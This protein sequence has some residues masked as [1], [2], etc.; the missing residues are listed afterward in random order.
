MAELDTIV[1]H[2][3]SNK[4]FVQEYNGEAYTIKAKD[5]RSF[6]KFVGYHIAK[7]LSSKMISDSFTKKMRKENPTLVSQKLIYDTPERRIYLFDIL[8][9]VSLVKEVV[10]AY[11]FRG[12]IGEMDVYEKYVAKWESEQKKDTKKEEKKSTT[13]ESKS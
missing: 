3:P 2:N 6:A 5:T 7:H 8:R 13:S 4:D 12:F 11:P 1:L 9:D 10:N